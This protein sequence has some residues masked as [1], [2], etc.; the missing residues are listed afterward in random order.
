MAESAS[1]FAR[2]PQPWVACPQLTNPAGEN[3]VSAAADDSLPVKI[4]VPGE[5]ITFTQY[6]PWQTIIQVTLSEGELKPG[7]SLRVA[8]GDRAAGGPGMHVQPYDELRYGLKCYADILGNGENICR[9][10]RRRPSRLSPL[11]R[12]V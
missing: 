4:V 5:E 8:I 11:S 9:S 2:D 6:H 7:R 1:P 10:K 12:I 3:Y